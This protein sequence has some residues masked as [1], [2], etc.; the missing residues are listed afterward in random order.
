[1]CEGTVMTDGEE[2]TPETPDTLRGYV[3]SEKHRVFLADLL[4]DPPH[5]CVRWPD[6]FSLVDGEPALFKVVNDPLRS[7]RAVR[8]FLLQR[9][10]RFATTQSEVAGRTPD[11]WNTLCVNPRHL[12]WLSPEDQAR[13]MLFL[14]AEQEDT[15]QE[16]VRDGISRSGALGRVLAPRGLHKGVRPD[17]LN[18]RSWRHMY[19]ELRLLVR[20]QVSLLPAEHQVAFEEALKTFDEGEK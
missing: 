20:E 6:S 2:R 7:E 14:A 17:P 11:C 5:E 3:F 15:I 16:L 4:N 13:K 19:E 9:T 10:R 1:M 8:P 18:R 12:A